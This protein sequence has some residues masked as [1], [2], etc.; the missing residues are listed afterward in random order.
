VP[1]T[2]GPA[3]LIILATVAVMVGACDHGGAFIA[4]N[5]TDQELIARVTGS[6]QVPASSSIR[7]RPR[8]DLLALPANSR[9]A[10][11]VLGFKDPF[12]VQKIEILTTDLRCNRDVRPSLRR[13]LRT[14]RSGHHHR[15]WPDRQSAPG[16][17]PDGHPC[18]EDRAMQRPES[19]SLTD[20]G[21]PKSLARGSNLP[22]RVLLHDR[23]IAEGPQIAA[24][25]FDPLSVGRRSGQG[26]LRRPAVAIDE[27]LILE[28]PN[29]RD[30]REAGG[31]GA[32]DLVPADVPGTPGFRSP[33]TFEDGVVGEVDHDPVEVVLIE[34]RRD[35]LE[36]PHGIVVVHEFHL[37]D[38]SPA[39]VPDALVASARQVSLGQA[40]RQAVWTES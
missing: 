1:V 13:R 16:V 30:P 39:R 20:R 3:R 22:V 2:A 15:S 6:E 29:I 23:A 11:E 25:D 34:G 27:V 37:L 18:R 7:H 38:G 4:E 40:T 28:I 17:S 14:R 33:R 31:E 24:A 35:R 21:D 9:L 19:G 26:P 5:K 36:H 12:N 10:I 8:Q 32:S